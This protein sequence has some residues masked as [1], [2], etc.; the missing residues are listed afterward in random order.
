MDSA[1][2][3][4]SSMHFHSVCGG[5]EGG[6]VFGVGFASETTLVSSPTLS[7]CYPLIAFSLSSFNTTLTLATGNHSPCFDSVISGV[8]VSQSEFLIYT[9]F[10]HRFQFLTIGHQCLLMNFHV[11]QF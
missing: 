11:V 6:A 5:S 4:F 7:F 10:H 3:V 9:S 8:K 2:E 1:S